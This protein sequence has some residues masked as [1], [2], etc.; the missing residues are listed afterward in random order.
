MPTEPEPIFSDPAL[1]EAI[2]RYRQYMRQSFS[3]TRLF[4]RPDPVPLEGLFTDVYVFDRP[5]AWQGFD[6]EALQ[7][8]PG[9]GKP[10]SHDG[11]QVNALELAARQDRLFIL[12]KPGAG[13]T[14]FLKYLTLQA[15]AGKLDRVPIF[16]A[17]NEWADSESDLLSFIAWQFEMGD[18]PR[19]MVQSVLKHGA[20]LVCF[21]GLDEVNAADDKRAA[22]TRAIRDFANQYPHNKVV[23]TCRRAAADDGFAEFT[24]VELADFTDE[25]VQVFARKWFAPDEATALRFV[26]EWQRAEQRGLRELPQTPLLLTLLCLNFAETPTFPARQ[27]E[28]YEAALDALLKKWD[29]SHSIKRDQAYYGLSLGRKRQLLARLAADYFGH[30]ETFFRQSDLARRITAFLKNLPASEQT[31]EPDGEAVLK[32]I[33]VQHGLLIEQ[34]RRIY[35][36]SHLTLQEYFTAKYLV[37][38]A[39]GLLA[40][41][42]KQYFT[43][44]RWREVFLLTAS[45]LP[46]ADDFLAAFQRVLDDLIRGDERLLAYSR[47]AANKAKDYAYLGHPVVARAAAHATVVR[48]HDYALVFARLFDLAPHDGLTLPLDLAR[49]FDLDL[50]FVVVLS[51]ARSRQRQKVLQEWPRLVRASVHVGPVEFAESLNNLRVPGENAN[52]LEWEA[53]AYKFQAVLIR[54]RNI[55]HEWNFTDE[56]RVRLEQYETGTRLL[57]ECLKLAAVSDRKAIESRLLLPPEE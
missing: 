8:Q 11:Q 55:G 4:G 33:E 56:Q 9:E 13:K 42:V 44:A 38:H 30:G 34:A 19:S 16:I 57:A 3:T 50:A 23:I 18:L 22:I 26:A 52:Y 45:M 27:A 17:L 2:E 7:V 14:T 46:E 20:A 6:I 40:R 10:F 1:A 5:T 37:D 25:Q 43:D 39:A 36:F 24:Y 47:W 54:Y 32:A 53:Y 35:A 41:F 28:L 12:G 49:G 29:A 21:D 51:C 31:D 15:A 48:N